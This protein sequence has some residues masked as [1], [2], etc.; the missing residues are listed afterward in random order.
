MVRKYSLKEGILY[1]TA[2]NQFKQAFNT[3]YHTNLET[4]INNYKSKNGLKKLTTPQYLTLSGKIE[5]ALRVAD[6]MLNVA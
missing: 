3:A 1:N 6:K 5:D 4:L 2:W